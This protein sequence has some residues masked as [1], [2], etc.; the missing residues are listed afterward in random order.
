M[1][2][3]FI[4][5]LVVCTHM[6]G[7][8]RD[9]GVHGQLWPVKERDMRELLMESAAKVDWD[10]VQ[11]ETKRNAETYLDR[12]PKR[13]MPQARRDTLI[14]MDP[15]FTVAQDI[16]APVKQASGSLAWQVI[17][18]RG[19]KANPL[20]YV[21]PSTALFF[22]DGADSAQFELAKALSKTI[23][24]YLMFI[25]AGRGGLREASSVL[26]RPVYHANDALLS[27]FGVRS[28]P[29]LVFPGSKDKAGFLGIASFPAPYT[30]GQVRRYWPEVSTNAARVA[31]PTK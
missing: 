13:V 26:G 2:A 28:V 30:E 29:T 15:S 14:W 3:L 4:G 9:L 24:D 22:Y 23:P 21:R 19:Q 31:A 8:A 5:V 16:A 11:A 20:Q 6:A 18:P 17:V 10:S 27:R 7:G 12:L 1:K 25:E